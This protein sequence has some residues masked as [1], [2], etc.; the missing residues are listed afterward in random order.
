M[1]KKT[2]E[3]RRATK[4]AYRQANR[5]RYAALQKQYRIRNA[6]KV[7]ERKRRYYFA[8]RDRILADTAKWREENREHLR[9]YNR[10]RTRRV[11]ANTRLSRYGVTDQWVIDKTA[12]QGNACAICKTEFVRTPCV[13]HDHITGQVRDLLCQRCNHAIG[14]FEHELT[15]AFLAYVERHKAMA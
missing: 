9:E 13:D 7:R 5:E 2:P 4:M 14:Y 6:D 12:S 8:N 15:E 10:N 11:V 1:T 3:E